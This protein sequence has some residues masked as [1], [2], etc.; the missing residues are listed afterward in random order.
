MNPSHFYAMLFRMKYINRWGLMNNTRSENISEHSH[1]V[2]IL[3]H[4]LV[5]IHNK[6]FGGSL[7]PERAALLAVYHD[8]SEII[9]GDL[10]TPVKYQ[11]SDIIAAY[12]QIEDSAADRL[13]SLL[14]EDFR[15]E[16]ASVIKQT[17]SG[18]EQLHRFV[19]AAD[20]FSAL[21]KCVDE[22]RMG[23][24]EFRKAKESIETSIH[25]MQLPEA[26]VFFEEFM[27]SFYL[28]LDEQDV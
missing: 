20:R 1:Q 15:D 4:C 13:I 5:L 25:A 2:A 28:S 11:N 21:I 14:P 27:P 7:N 16:Y 3:A 23:N 24:D 17:G 10:P 19:K 6:R 8:A 18:D 9:T 22:L 12:K 26:E